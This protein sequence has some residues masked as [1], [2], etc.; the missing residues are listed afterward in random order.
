MLYVYLDL[1]GPRIDMAV[2]NFTVQEGTTLSIPLSIDANPQPD[3]F[4][5]Y[6]Q[7]VD[8]SIAA[9]SSVIEFTDISRD[10]AGNYSL[11]ISN[12]ISTVMYTFT[13]DVT[14]EL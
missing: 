3:P 4:T 5:L 1:D 6:Y 11:K 8:I 14:C 9:N 7:N 12:N 10:Q 2:N 13:V